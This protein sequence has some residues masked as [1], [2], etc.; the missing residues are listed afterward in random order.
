M[1]GRRMAGLL[2]CYGEG[3][4]EL[5]INPEHSPEH[6]AYPKD[7]ELMEWKLRGSITSEEKKERKINLRIT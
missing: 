4:G 2:Y 1:N 5:T 7:T 3:K 6:P